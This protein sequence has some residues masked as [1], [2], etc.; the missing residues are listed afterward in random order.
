M[1]AGCLLVGLLV[2]SVAIPGGPGVGPARAVHGVRV[3]ASALSVPALTTNT[4]RL[5]VGMPLNASVN[6]SAITGGSGNVTNLTFAWSGLPT[7]CTSQNVS[8]YTCYPTVVG[9]Y[10][11]DVTVTDFSDQ[12]T[13]TAPKITITVSSDPVVAS[14]VASTT[15]LSVNQSVTFTV[16]ASGGTAPLLYVFSGLPAGCTG[17]TS[18]VT[19]TPTTAQAYHVSVSV[20]DA[21]NFSSNSQFVVVRV[22]PASAHSSTATPS[23]GQWAVIVGILVVGLAL[24]GYLWVRARREDRLG[25]SAPPRTSPPPPVSP[26]PDHPPPPDG[27]GR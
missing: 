12:Q 17:N 18:T 4:S 25:R 5:D 1:G 26:P 16:A 3:V 6:A 22:A 27:P 24:A 21:V 11:V 8:N 9:T 10:S 19:C 13:G 7:N 2:V 23:A 15:N 14:I 20:L